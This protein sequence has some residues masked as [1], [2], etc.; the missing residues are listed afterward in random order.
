LAVVLGLIPAP[1]AAGRSLPLWLEI[2]AVPVG[3]STLL[4]MLLT[5]PLITSG[6]SYLYR[7][8]T[9]R[10]R[11]VSAWT[12]VT[13]VGVALEYVIVVTVL[14]SLV[15]RGIRYPVPAHLS[16]HWVILGAGV[17]AT[18][19]AMTGILASARHRDPR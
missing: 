14:R 9:A 8:T 10:W 18:A 6:F 19:A 13:T 7:A 1:T 5:A 11:W 3:V 4:A 17:I 12:G 2:A 16:W 15:P